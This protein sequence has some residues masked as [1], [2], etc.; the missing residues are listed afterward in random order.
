LRGPTPLASGGAPRRGRRRA[1]SDPPPA[2][3]PARSSGRGGSVPVRIGAQDHRTLVKLAGDRGASSF[4]VL[5]AALAALMSRLGA[6]EDIAVG[7]PVAGRTDDA[8]TELVGFFVNTLVLRADT[9]GSPAFRTLVERV[10]R[11]DVA[12]YAHQ[13]LPFEQVVEELAPTRSLSRHPLFQVMLSLN[14]TPAPRPHLDGLTVG[15][16]R[17]VGRSGSKFDLSWDLSEHH[18]GQGRPDGITGELE[19]D[20][21]LFDRT[22]ADRFAEHFTRLLSALLS[23]PDRPMTDVGFLTP[24]QRAAAVDE[25][26]HTARKPLAARP[27]VAADDDGTVL[28]VLAT[29]AAVQPD[30]TAVVAE[31]KR[32]TFGELRLLSDRLACSLRDRGVEAGDRVAVALPRTSLAVVAVLGILRAG[33]VYVPLDPAQPAA[34]TSLILGTAVP[35]LVLATS[36]TRAALPDTADVLLLDGAAEQEGPAA[37]TMPVPPRGRDAAY[38]LYTSGSTGLPK[39]VVVEHRSLARLLA[40]HRDRLMGPAEAENNGLPLRVAHTAAMTFDA[41]LDPLLWMI[42]GHELHLVDDMTRRGPPARPP[43][44]HHPGQDLLCN[45]PPEEAH[46]R[47]SAR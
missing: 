4:M 10:T 37:A 27:G 9:S 13:E 36:A 2:P 5:H 25:L 7:T 18:D 42:A 11:T 16:E 26:P 40:H 24:S 34:R 45:N 14:N 47:A 3:R 39:G 31:D 32:L 43:H 29:R 22:T 1:R 12:A 44:P 41:S 38:V 21:D 19:Y 6:G 8:L 35:R 28:D 15:H 30:R 33:A 17:S 23:E 20:E 46:P